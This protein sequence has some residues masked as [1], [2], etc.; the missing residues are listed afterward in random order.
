MA[1]DPDNADRGDARPLAERLGW[2][3][4]IW[5][6]SVGVIGLVAYAIRWWINA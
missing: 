3:V 2:M 4:V 5:L 1:L 6:I